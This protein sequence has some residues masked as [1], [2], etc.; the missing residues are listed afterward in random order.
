MRYVQTGSARLEILASV[1]AIAH[2]PPSP[3]SC[4][5]GNQRRET[6]QHVTR[7]SSKN[8]AEGINNENASRIK[9]KLVVCRG[10]SLVG[11]VAAHVLRGQV[12]ADAAR[13]INQNV[14][15]C[16]SHSA[17]GPAPP[18]VPSRRASSL[19]LPPPQRTNRTHCDWR[20]MF[21]TFDLRA[22]DSHYTTSHHSLLSDK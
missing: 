18:P 10:K 19:P 13:R 15:T 20:Q 1:G 8:W 22:I 3:A 16:T 4:F 21:V 17:P 2:P 9:R 11:R 12:F 6:M 14:R 7:R 5:W